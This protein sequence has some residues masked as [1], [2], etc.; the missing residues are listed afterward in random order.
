MLTVD[1]PQ[2]RSHVSPV[3]DPHEPQFVYLVD[4]LGLSPAP[5]R[6]SPHEFR[7]L[8]W[9]DGRRTVHDIQ[10]EAMRQADGEHQPLEPLADL[11]RC[12]G[13]Y[14]GEPEALR[15]QLS[16][17]FT[18]PKGPGRPRDLRPDNTLRAALVP[19]ID[20]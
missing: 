18:G 5:R 9:F 3:R 13:C 15:R 19:H 14:E 2:L 1:R 16:R 17:L 20:Y 12:V 6:L 4:H 8:R 7:W 11:V 10:L